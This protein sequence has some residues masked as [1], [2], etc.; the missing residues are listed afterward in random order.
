MRVSVSAKDTG[1]SR[2]ARTSDKND[3]P[4]CSCGILKQLLV[5]QRNH[6][7]T[8]QDRVCGVFSFPSSHDGFAGCCRSSIRWVGTN[9]NIHPYYIGMV[10][11]FML[12][13]IR[14]RE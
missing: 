6:G 14:S 8:E 5:D 9:D 7:G 1:M 10:N 12:M 2:L 3:F 11:T 13:P 4:S